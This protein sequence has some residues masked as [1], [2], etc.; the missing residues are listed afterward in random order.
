MS[1]ANTCALAVA[2]TFEWAFAEAMSEYNAKCSLHACACMHIVL[3]KLAPRLQ[4][5]NDVTMRAPGQGMQQIISYSHE[6]ATAQAYRDV[7]VSDTQYGCT[8]NHE[9]HSGL[10]IVRNTGEQ[11]DTTNTIGRAKLVHDEIALRHLLPLVE[12][13]RS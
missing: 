9:N 8:S 12:A 3:A 11:D 10:V 7:L 6:I 5:N 13:S 1:S 2:L 4:C